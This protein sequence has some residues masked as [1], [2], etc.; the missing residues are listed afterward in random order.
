M[1]ASARQRFAPLTEAAPR[2]ATRCGKTLLL[3]AVVL[4]V[5]VLAVPMLAPGLAAQQQLAT[6]LV[7]GD[8]P[9][10]YDSRLYRADTANGSVQTLYQQTMGRFVDVV[11]D[12]D[13]V[14]FAAV[15][16]GP[17]S[18]GLHFM[19]H[20]GGI[21]SV[22][23]TVAT[24]G[25]LLSCVNLTTEDVWAFGTVAQF[26]RSRLRGLV[27]G[28]SNFV[29]VDNFGVQSIDSFVIERSQARYVFG[30]N[31]GGGI[32]LSYDVY[33]PATQTTLATNLGTIND[34]EQDPYSGAFLVAT[35]R[36]VAPITMVLPLGASTI[37]ATYSFPLSVFPNGVTVDAMALGTRNNGQ[38]VP[39]WV[40]AGGRVFS[41]F[42]NTDQLRVEFPTPLKSF[43]IPGGR[44]T[45]MILEGDRD[46]LLTTVQ[47][48]PNQW[49]LKLRL[50]PAL[51]GKPYV[52]GAS[53]A[54]QPGIKVGDGR[55]INLRPDRF[56][57]LVNQGQLGAIFQ[58]FQGTTTNE[59]EVT[60][61]VTSTQSW[62]NALRN[63]TVYFAGI[64]L[65]PSV[66][67]GIRTISNTVGLQLQ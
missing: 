14:S 13:N 59:G 37:R 54:P 48:A 2:P 43:P 57:F 45:S 64:V 15:W 3:L 5:P 40:A 52:L 7:T 6:L 10:P 61:K 31:G 32:L 39:L 17:Q 12:R 50:G 65:D 30:M 44:I 55:M 67:G 36:K 35:D 16:Q 62:R 21:A 19:T 49:A 26:G 58:D 23:R 25:P 41:L 28:T 27:P 53:L 33:A 63:M 29:D 60:G 20:N 46:F 34:V 22:R 18:S 51:A 8:G 4:T 9:N 38:R 42:W 24:G 66:P 1:R 11:M 56:F 47:T